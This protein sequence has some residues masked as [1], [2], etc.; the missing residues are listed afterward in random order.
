MLCA[1]LALSF[2]FLV[3][4]CKDNDD[5]GAGNRKVLL[6]INTALVNKVTSRAGEDWKTD[7]ERMH[8]LRV[9]IVD[10]AGRVEYNHPV[11]FEQI[12]LDEYNH[13]GDVGSDERGMSYGKFGELKF[14]VVP[15]QR[16][17]IYLFANAEGL[18]CK[19]NTWN[20]N[21]IRQKLFSE[22]RNRGTGSCRLWQQ[23]RSSHECSSPSRCRR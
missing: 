20:W 5:A 7:P 19:G 15:N 18:E 2:P 23:G 12:N 9:I 10:E 8:N 6:S 1:G 21:E 13:A 22:K 4:G 14:P 17:S 16:K 3:G 11:N